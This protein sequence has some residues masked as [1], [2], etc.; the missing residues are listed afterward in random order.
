[1]IKQKF[2]I[3]NPN[4]GTEHIVVSESLESAISRHREQIKENTKALL[5]IFDFDR[6]F[7]TI[8]KPGVF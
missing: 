1:M 4:A 7:L 6:K 2:I 3:K 8:S 5:S